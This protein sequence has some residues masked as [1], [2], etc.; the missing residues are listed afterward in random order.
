MDYLLAINKSFNSEIMFSNILFFF[1]Q[2][3]FKNSQT[4][5]IK[6]IPAD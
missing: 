4:F 5:F 3:H 6:K 1:I 2:K